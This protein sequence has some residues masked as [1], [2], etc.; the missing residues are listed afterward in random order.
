MEEHILVCL[1]PSPTNRKLIRTAAKM[2][3]AF[4]GEFTALYVETPDF[5]MME[6]KAKERL[7]ENMRLAQQLGA[8]VEILQGDDV[9]FQIAEFA[10]LSGVTKAVIG[11]SPGGMP[12]FLK[13]A[14]L[15]E[16]VLM[17]AP[18]LEIHIIPD[19]EAEMV[20]W[21]K[22]RTS[23]WLVFSISDMI[24]SLGVLAAASLLGWIFD[25][26]GFTE[27]NIITVYVLA[28]L[29]I[30]AVTRNRIYSLISSI[31]SVLTFNFLF[32]YP[33]FTLHAYEKGYPVTFVVMFIVA[34][35][36][37]TL[38]A[39]L[40]KN[41]KQSAR[42]AFRTKTLF[43]VNQMMQ[44]AQGKEEIFSAAAH[45]LSRLLD[46]DIILYPVERGLLG[47]PVFLPGEDGGR[48][49]DYMD[50]NERRAAAWSL[51]NNKRSG[52][53]TRTFSDAKCLYLAIRMKNK[54]YGIAGIAVGKEPVKPFENSIMLSI[55]GEC[56]MALENLKNAEEKEQAAVMAK[57][58]Q[59]RANLLRSISHDLRT[60]LTS[61]S[62]NA[63]NLLSNGD[64]FDKE[65]RR[66]MYQD[67]YDDSMW[68]ISLVEN[69][70][71]VT[72]LEE[73]RPN[74][75]FTAELV[76][77]VVKEALRHMNRVQS[78]HVVTVKHEEELLLAKM[79]V[80]LI[81]QVITNLVDNAGKYT[82]KGSR[83][84][85]RTGRRGEMA[86]ISVA[87]DG[88]GIPDQ[89]KDKVFEMFY[90]GAERIA[91]SRRSMG[92]GLALCRLI[93]NAHG[94]TLELSDNVPRGAVFEFTL[95]VEEVCI[96]E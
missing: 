93:I 95:P 57:N 91:D 13:K 2:A 89:Q 45:Q 67:I 43:D 84:E 20:R 87:D 5:E 28:V 53:A 24:K 32:T 25:R 66:G 16:L 63:G 19:Q 47:D 71:S 80:R 8:A 58:E 33:R 92:L 39:K 26:S 11:R 10:R 59:L 82:P 37:G 14:S 44:Q 96:H 17:H 78:E 79:D 88:P 36:T 50:E 68:L 65:T 52:A 31:I 15:S 22:R 29:V 81:V 62:G 41:A 18:D 9:P 27:A 1:S 7:R 69:L 94:G 86:V 38:A 74:F 42:V 34:L 4:R 55:I 56:A 54:V 83:I 49:E 61:I 70:L 72:R 51:K 60:P 3:G 40:K 85:I 6:E 46:K 35:I 77:E 64:S 73:G 21:R 23:D 76:D 30:S 12:R 48:L 75:H 90:S